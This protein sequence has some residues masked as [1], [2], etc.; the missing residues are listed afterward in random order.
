MKPLKYNLTT[1]KKPATGKIVLIGSILVSIYWLLSKYINI[2]HF[3]LA[4]AIFELLWLPMMSMLFV[5]PIISIISMA[6]GKLNVR[7]P[8]LHSFLIIA[9]TILILVFGK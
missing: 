7:S 5:L 8:Y 4:G 3:A 6:G 9:T 1:L 2:Y